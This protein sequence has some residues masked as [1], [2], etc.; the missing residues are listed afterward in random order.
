MVE[1]H[2]CPS[3]I[4]NVWE[5]CDVVHETI[6]VINMS[7]WKECQIPYINWNNELKILQHYFVVFK[8]LRIQTIAI[9]VVQVVLVTCMYFKLLICKCLL[10]TN[11]VYTMIVTWKQEVALI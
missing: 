1:G 10:H 2:P 11:N 4:E 8:T 6:R 7:H 5:R 3:T 9:S